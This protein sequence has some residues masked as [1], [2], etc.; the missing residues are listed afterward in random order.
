MQTTYGRESR[1]ERSRK[2]R[3]QRRAVRQLRQLLVCL[4]VFAL[5]FVGKGVWPEQTARTGQ[6]LLQLLH[7][8]TDVRGLFVGLGS[9]LSGEETSW[10]ELRELYTQAFAP[11]ERQ[12]QW[13]YT[14][15][16]PPVY[17][18]IWREQ[19]RV[20][21]PVPEPEPDPNQNT[22]PQETPAE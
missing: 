10:K 1:Q 20:P 8:N 22:V 13:R 5:V 14:P 4:A 2:Q 19:E 17:R 12:E 3:R 11:G 9:V 18:P 6:Q 16:Q 7:A 21:M 15:G